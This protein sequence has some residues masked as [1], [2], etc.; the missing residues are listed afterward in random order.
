MPPVVSLPYHKLANWAVHEAGVPVQCADDAYG[1][2]FE[3]IAKSLNTYVPEWGT[4]PETWARTNAFHHVLEWQREWFHTR[5]KK[6][7]YDLEIRSGNVEPWLFDLPEDDRT[8]EVVSQVAIA[9]LL[10]VP[11]LTLHESEVLHHIFIDS[12]S[13]VK[14]GEIYGV[15]SS[16]ICQIKNE[17]IRKLRSHSRAQ[18]RGKDL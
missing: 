9:D 10:A 7:D 6:G 17:A 8:D 3:G 11:E 13:L 4:T 5:H 1:A 14:V 12:L 18:L 2:A 16:R 15:S